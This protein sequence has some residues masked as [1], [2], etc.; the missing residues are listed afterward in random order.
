M[1]VML[2]RAVLGSFERFIGILIENYSGKLPLWLAPRQVVVASIVSGADDYVHEVVAALRAAGLRAEAD[3]RN[4]KDQLQGPRAF[5]RQGA[6]H[7]AVGLK[8][9]EERS[10]SIRRLDRQGSESHGLE[11]AIATLR[12]E[13][14]P[15]D[16]R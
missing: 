6:G 2:H 14:T 15:P 9:V 12:A 4:E 7:H 13:A 1:P 11:S 5:G 8:E 3:T 16:L 10:V